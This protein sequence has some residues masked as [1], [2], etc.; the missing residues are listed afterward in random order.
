MINDPRRSF[1]RKPRRNFE[2]ALVKFLKNFG[3]LEEFLKKSM[4]D[5]VEE[6]LKEFLKDS[7]KESLQGFLEKRL[8][9]FLNES[10]KGFLISF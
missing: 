6:F 4:E 2:E 1:L 3:I 7:L 8:E 5:F 9:D 10:L